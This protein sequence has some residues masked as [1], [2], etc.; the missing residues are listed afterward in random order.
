MTR[1]RTENVFDGL[2]QV[3]ITEDHPK[4]KFDSVIS[5]LISP[6]FHNL[7]RHPL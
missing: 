6:H 2:A 4:E 3:F 1:N 5:P 7:G